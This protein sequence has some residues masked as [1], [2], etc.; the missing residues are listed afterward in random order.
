MCDEPD[1]HK[2][3]LSMVN[4]SAKQSHFSVKSWVFMLVSY[5]IGVL[6]DYEEINIY[7]FQHKVQ[8]VSR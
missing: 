4:F 1:V 7:E 2:M 6:Y 3:F 5:L 8:K